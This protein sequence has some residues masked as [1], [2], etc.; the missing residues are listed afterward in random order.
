MNDALRYA[1][2]IPQRTHQTANQLSEMVTE[3][4]S[5]GE[6]TY[7]EADQILD[8]YNDHNWSI[9]A[10]LKMALAEHGYSIDISPSVA[11]FTKH[12]KKLFSLPK[13]QLD[14]KKQLGFIIILMP[15]VIV[16]LFRLLG[17]I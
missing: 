8:I 13:I 2:W 16:C 7:A 15:I 4:L 14:N 17:A 3:M 11:T 1:A 9:N 12:K 5:D 10:T 6:L